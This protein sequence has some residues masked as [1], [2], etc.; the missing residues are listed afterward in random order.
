MKV[1]AAL[2]IGILA[3]T[4]PSSVYANVS[5]STYGGHTEEYDGWKGIAV[6]DDN[7]DN[8]DVYSDFKRDIGT[9]QVWRVSGGC[10][11]FESTGITGNLVQRF[12]HC[13][14]DAGPNTC[15]STKYR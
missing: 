2:A 1:A 9:P 5:A 4:V 10:G 11:E 13:T 8:N 15:S 6:F 7:C 14:D 3:W 12:N